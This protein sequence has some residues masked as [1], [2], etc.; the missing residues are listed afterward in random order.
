RGAG[1]R[2][3]GLPHQHG[4]E[5]APANHLVSQCRHEARP[6]T[7]VYRDSGLLG[8]NRRVAPHSDQGL[9][10]TGVSC[11]ARIMKATLKFSSDWTETLTGD[12]VQGGEITV[13]YDLQRLPEHR[14]IYKGAAIWD[15][16]GLVR[17]QPDR[18]ILATSLTAPV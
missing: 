11:A 10:R 13:D 1:Q 7:G 6:G 17:F 18:Q 16:R 8:H 4:N 15:V 12:L 2:L 14:S 5:R 9:T 3:H